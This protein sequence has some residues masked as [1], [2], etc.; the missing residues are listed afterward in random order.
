MRNVCSLLTLVLALA[1]TVLAV[2]NTWDYAVLVSAGVRTS[3]PQ[4][5]LSWPQD[6]AAV[7]DS[8]TVYR[9]SLSATSWGAGTVLAGA[10]TSFTDN[11]VA[12][13]ASYEYQVFKTNAANHSSGYGYIYAGLNA[14]MVENR[15]T[16]VLI[17]D[18]TYAMELAN[19][20]GRLQQDLVGDGWTVLRHDV[21]RNDSVVN[22]KNLIQADYNADAA[23]VKA[24]FLFG[25]VPVPYSG[26]FAADFHMPAHQ[27]AWPADVYYGDMNGTWTDY[28]VNDSGAQ[29]SRNWNV[30]GDGK[31]DQSY[32]PSAVELEVG[33]V[34]L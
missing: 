4:I 10:V 22:V 27:G 19:E 14:P 16:V 13:G 7:P 8:Y 15:G 26:D 25:H 17:V 33:R 31:F 28:A 9:K 12:V 11:N 3:P 5:A 34:D 23:S 18:N 1:Q 20:L 32:P 2:E 24:V 6:T 29:S 30:R 21:G